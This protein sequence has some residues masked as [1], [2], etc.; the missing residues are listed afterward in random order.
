MR[1]RRPATFIALYDALPP[2][3]QRAAD[4][5]FALFKKD[6]GHPSLHRKTPERLKD[7]PKAYVEVRVTLQYRAVAEAEGEDYFWIFIGTH[8]DFDRF[9]DRRL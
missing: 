7:R 6:Q 8:A 9:V 4:K 2:T 1:S 3:V 5:Q